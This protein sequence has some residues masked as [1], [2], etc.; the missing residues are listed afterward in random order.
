MKENAYPNLLETFGRQ[1]GENYDFQIFLTSDAFNIFRSVPSGIFL[2]IRVKP[3]FSKLYPGTGT[4]KKRN[5][6]TI[7][8][9]V[10]I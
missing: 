9:L 1:T 8:K 10:I 2:E 3:K 6:S 5:E 7:G 4:K